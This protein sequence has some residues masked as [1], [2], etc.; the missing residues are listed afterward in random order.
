MKQSPIHFACGWVCKLLSNV[1]LGMCA[2][3]NKPPWIFALV[4]MYNQT[5]DNY[6]K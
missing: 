4:L 6:K 5:L 2:T 3:G 1:L